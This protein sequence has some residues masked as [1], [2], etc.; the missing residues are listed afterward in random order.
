MYFQQRNKAWKNW[1]TNATPALRQSLVLKS[2]IHR[3]YT[4][5]AEVSSVDVAYQT[6]AIGCSTRIYKLYTLAFSPSNQHASVARH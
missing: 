4:A 6:R 3:Q 5:S 1:A 2:Q